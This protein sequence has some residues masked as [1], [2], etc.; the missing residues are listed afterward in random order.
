MTYADPPIGQT[1]EPRAVVERAVTPSPYATMPGQQLSPEQMAEADLFFAQLEEEAEFE[2]WKYMCVRV[3]AHLQEYFLESHPNPSAAPPPPEA[4][5]TRGDASPL[6]G[7]QR[8][9]ALAR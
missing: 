5:A 8:D 1:A 6:P 4:D 3:P 2:S 9:P 7:Y